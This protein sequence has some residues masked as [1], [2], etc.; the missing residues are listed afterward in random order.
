MIG[1]HNSLEIPGYKDFVCSQ[2]GY[3]VCNWCS[4]FDFKIQIMN[5]VL[6]YNIPNISSNRRGTEK[7]LWKRITMTGR[8]LKIKTAS[9]WNKDGDIGLSNQVEL[10]E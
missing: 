1:N 7:E 8:K 5:L 2:S 3:V 4:G 9:H 6:Q 10:V